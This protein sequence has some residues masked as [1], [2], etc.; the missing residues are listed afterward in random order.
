MHSVLK[1]APLL[2]IAGCATTAKPVLYPN[3][4]LQKRGQ[5]AAAAEQARCA[6]LAEQA[7]TADGETGALGEA[8]RGA[9]GGALV[10]AAVGS[11]FGDARTGAQAGA[12]RGGASGFLS[13]LRK[14][15]PDPLTRRFIE[16]CLAEKGYEVI[17]WK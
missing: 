10:G 17:G 12:A 7:G 9:A 6:Q 15:K 13:G 14:Q 11:V 16:R 4:T 2:L 8:G 5:S 3:E 1:L